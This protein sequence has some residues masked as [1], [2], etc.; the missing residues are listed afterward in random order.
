MR[1]KFIP[2]GKKQLKIVK[3]QFFLYQKA[4]QVRSDPMYGISGSKTLEE[5]QDTVASR[6]RLRSHMY[7]YCSGAHE[8]CIVQ[9]E[10]PHLGIS[11]HK[12]TLPKFQT[13]RNVPRVYKI[14]LRTGSSSIWNFICCL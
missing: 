9:M 6:A 12:E 11:C 10:E 4:S 5:I 13:M 7:E 1:Q 14:A 2:A 3:T 8:L